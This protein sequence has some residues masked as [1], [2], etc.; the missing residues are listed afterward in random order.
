MG[1]LWRI[2]FGFG[3]AISEGKAPMKDCLHTES[4]NAD[5]MSTWKCKR[6]KADSRIAI[7]MHMQGLGL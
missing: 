2:S 7:N 5:G 3:I 4:R 6:K 1:C